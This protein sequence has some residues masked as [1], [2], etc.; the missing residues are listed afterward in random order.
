MAD[1]EAF[2]RD[3]HLRFFAG[4]GASV[5]ETAPVVLAR[6]ELLCDGADEG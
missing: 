4:Y 3:A 6:F 2:W 1:A 5:E